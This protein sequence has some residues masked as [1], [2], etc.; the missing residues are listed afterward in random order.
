MQ[1]VELAPRLLHVSLAAGRSAI[2]FAGTQERAPLVAGFVGFLVTGLGTRY[3]RWCSR[4]A[5]LSPSPFRPRA[6]CRRASA[7]SSSSLLLGIV[8]ASTILG[9]Y[10][11]ENGNEMSDS[12]KGQA[13]A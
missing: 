10:V 1:L 11:L 9:N 6:G 8:L 7:G 5:F 4:V 12:V 2:Y 3:R 13:G